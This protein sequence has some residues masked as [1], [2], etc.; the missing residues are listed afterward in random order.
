MG[1]VGR[2]RREVEEEGLRRLGLMLV[3]HQADRLV[4]EVLGEVVAVA[5]WAGLVDIAVVAHQ[6]GR[7]L[8]RVAGEE[9][10]VT[11]E[12]EPERPP[13]ERPRR[14][15]LP[16]GRETPLPDGEGAVPDVAEQPGHRRGRG[17]DPAVVARVA[18]RDVAQEAHPDGVVVPAR[19][20]ARP[21]R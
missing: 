13:T 4:D 7:P 2:A 12:A 20:Q 5:G 14:A 11:L 6:R 15:L 10:V 17:R 8:V 16:T 3:L 18:G 21:R 19:E 9:A 1:R